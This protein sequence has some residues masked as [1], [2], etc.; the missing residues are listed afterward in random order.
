MLLK[1]KKLTAPQWVGFSLIWIGAMAA[2]RW[3]FALT[4]L[5]QAIPG[6]SEMGLVAPIMLLAS[7]T[8]CVL[9]GAGAKAG[10]SP[11]RRKVVL[12]CVCLLTVFP[13]LMLIEHLAGVDLGVDFMRDGLNPSPMI[14]FPGRMSPNACVAFGLGSLVIYLFL[15]P[16]TAARRQMA[17]VF[18]IG[19][20]FIGAAGCIGHVLHFERLYKVAAA[21]AL[22]LPVA[23]GLTF[24]SAGLWLLRERWIAADASPGF[25]RHEQRIGQRSIAVLAVVAIAAGVGGFA[26]IQETYEKSQADTMLLTATA[27]ADSLA[28]LLE[29]SAW[30]PRALATRP[31]VSKA[32]EQLQ[33][34]P[35]DAEQGAGILRRAGQSFLSAGLRGIRFQDNAGAEVAAV[36]QFSVKP[37]DVALALSPEFASGRLVWKEGGGYALHT[38]H[39][40]V[41]QGRGVGFITTE[42][43]LPLF[44]KLVAGMR[45]ASASSDAL[46]C[47]RVDEAASC[48]P[49]RFYAAPFSIPMRAADGKPNFPINRALLGEVGV[50]VTRDLRGVQ[51]VAAY[52]PIAATGLALVVKA[53]AETLYAPLRD[54]MNVLA[55]TL[56]GLV[57]FGWW[58]LRSQVRPLVAQMAAEQRR[59]RVILENSNDAFIAIDG[60]GVITDWNSQ[61]QRTFGWAADE[62]VGQKLSALIIPPDQRAAHEAGFVRFRHSGTGPVVNQRLEVAALHRDGHTFMA[63]LSVAAFQERGGHVAHAFMRDITGRLAVQREIEESEKHLR[64]ITDNLP[65]LIGYIASERKLLFANQMFKHWIGLD[66][67]TLTGQPIEALGTPIYA[68]RSDLLA[69]SLAG[70]RVEYEFVCSALGEVRNLHTVLVPD[71]QVDGR[72]AGVYA[73]STDVSAN[74]A[75]E[76]HLNQLARVDSLTGLPNRR[77]FEERLDQ[78]MARSRRTKRPMALVFMDIDHFKGINDTLGHGVGDAVLKEVGTRLEGAIRVTD[79]AARLAGDEFVVIAEGLNTVE[80]AAFITEK[81]VESIRRPMTVK[82]KPLHVTA[83]MGLAYYTGDEGSSVEALIARADRALYR[84]KGA[85]RNTFA[86]TVF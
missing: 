6:F 64:D 73:L 54:R 28:S 5:Q 42:Q 74:K 71:V 37:T 1:M 48:V 26:V 81:L 60:E 10:A 86:A 61:A 69:A 52:T 25:Q 83:S 79:L 50:T 29:V 85:G 65:V 3:V 2:V 62:A 33:A 63:E 67:D 21:N 75:I 55:L 77:Q 12:A 39:T 72:V 80:E 76:Q 15:Q 57:A 78:A 20:S 82:G 22:S 44:D 47:N 34:S 49:S 27:N 84:A 18:I 45:R 51:V 14:A 38:T 41:E 43:D 70:E 7:G 24:L 68:E 46:V 23:Y 8:A 11:W 16:A 4:P 17:L 66:P 9:L 40:V 35:R 19:I 32:L 30:L 13:S 58:A 53:N 56:V 31:T 36:G 59:T